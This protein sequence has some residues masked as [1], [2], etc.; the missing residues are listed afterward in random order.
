MPIVDP[1][2]PIRNIRLAIS[3]TLKINIQ[4]TNTCM[5]EF[6]ITIAQSHSAPSASLPN[7]YELTLVANISRYLLHKPR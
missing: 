6:P 2:R 5:P 3:I 4:I 1:N 7:Q